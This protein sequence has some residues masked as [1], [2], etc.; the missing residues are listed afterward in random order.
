VTDIMPSDFAGSDI[1]PDFNWLQPDYQPVLDARARRLTYIHEHPEIL[2]ALRAFY[3]EH[4]AAF[5]SHWGWTRDP[6]G[7]TDRVVPFLLWPKQVECVEFISECWKAGKPGLIEKSRDS[8]ITH[9]CVALAATLC[10]FHRG[11]VIGFGSRKEEYV[12][13]KDSP[14]SIFAKLRDF[15]EQ[16]PPE[17]VGPWERERYSPHMRCLF[18][19]T[20]STIVG[21]AGDNIGRGDRA[22]LYFL[23][24]AAWL[25][26]P[27]SIEASLSATARCRIDVST[28]C[29]MEN[30]FARK[31]LSGRFAVFTAHWRNDPRR[32]PEWHA[33][34]CIELDEATF[35]QEYGIS[36]TASLEN[37]LIKPAW[38]QAAIGAHLKLAIYPAGERVG[39]FDPADQGAD[40]CAFAGRH[41]I[42]CE[43]IES[44]RGVGSN[45]LE[46][47]L[48]AVDHCTRLG[49]RELVY[50]AVGLGAGVSGYAQVI[51]G[52]RGKAG[53]PALKFTPYSGGASPPEGELRQG[54]PNAERYANRKAHDWDALAKLLEN[55]WRAVHLGEKV[56][57]DEIVSL[58]PWM[59]EL[60]D[61]VN[62]LSQ[63]TIKRTPAGRLLVDKYGDGA[64]SPNLADA[65]VMAFASHDRVALW[66]KLAGDG[67]QGLRLT[68]EEREA[69]LAERERFRQEEAQRAKAAGVSSDD[70]QWAAGE[71]AQAGPRPP[72]MRVTA[73]GDAPSGYGDMFATVGA[74]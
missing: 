19:Q 16:L 2:P 36:Y 42:L 40:R 68:R 20:G 15:V 74:A 39:A 28:P 12:D 23:D 35:A 59:P 4:P 37:Q 60:Q 33:Q 8:G 55:T 56:P 47:T 52:E 70:A 48:R 50:D 71:S 73:V 29:G 69:F 34:K 64:R 62:E 72:A 44:W 26:N 24:E 13:L 63:V 53:R 5:I 46:S 66:E 67:E 9:V 30:P 14:K 31:R 45:P 49:Y 32:T 57:V 21:E 7:L 27:E 1:P 51:N 61:L 38:I 41:G 11:L 43:F 25:E 6:R 17:F 22:A 3:A 18:P 58:D 65:L 10:L 54:I